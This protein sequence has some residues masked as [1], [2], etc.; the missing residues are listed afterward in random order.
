MNVIVRR[1]DPIVCFEVVL[2]YASFAL[3]QDCDRETSHDW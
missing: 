2:S 3:P 1:V